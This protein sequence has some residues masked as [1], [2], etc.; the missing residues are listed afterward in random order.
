M[1]TTHCGH[2]GA[3]AVGERTHSRSRNEENDEVRRTE[4]APGGGHG[5]GKG[6][7]GRTPATTGLWA[8]LDLL[9]PSVQRCPQSWVLFTVF[10]LI[11]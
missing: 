2:Q 8:G 9:E 3:R 10:N 4:R 11:H 5:S 7:E 1:A 6:V